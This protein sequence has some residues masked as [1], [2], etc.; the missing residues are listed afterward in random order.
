MKIG[1]IVGRFQVPEY[2]EGHLHLFKTVLN[3]NDKMLLIL[4]YEQREGL[5][6][7]RNPYTLNE[8]YHK[9]QNTFPNG[10]VWLNIIRDADSNEAWS[11][12]LDEMLDSYN[13]TPIYSEDGNVIELTEPHEITLYGSRDSFYQN[14]TT[15][16]YPFKHVDEIPGVSGTAVREALKN[17]EVQTV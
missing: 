5:N 11:E 12:Y 14:Y 16:K 13:R 17:E 6:R 1:V 4:G 15:K 9:A 2:H 3:E 8:R 7:E 10:N